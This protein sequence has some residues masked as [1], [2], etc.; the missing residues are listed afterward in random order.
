MTESTD[1]RRILYAEF[2]AVPG[3]EDAVVELVRGYADRV[4]A[5]PGNL[6]FSAARRKENPAAFFI[7]EEYVDL[8]AFRAHLD[9]EYGAPFNAALSPLIVE[10]TSVLTFLLPV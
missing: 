9:A 6:A 3:K 5:E 7:Y 1:R 10:P 8:D 4:R 2:T